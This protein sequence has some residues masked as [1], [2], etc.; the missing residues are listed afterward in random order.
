MAVG[1][2]EKQQR[3]RCA[4]RVGHPRGCPLTVRGDVLLPKGFKPS[5]KAELAEGGD[6]GLEN[7]D[8]AE[9][10]LAIVNGGEPHMRNLHPGII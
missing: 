9:G 10:P 4:H 8:E 1:C 2:C 6:A 3:I 7:E 5:R